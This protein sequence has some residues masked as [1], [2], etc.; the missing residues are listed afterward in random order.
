MSKLVDKI[1]PA[2]FKV[3]TPE[4]DNVLVLDFN[5]IIEQFELAKGRQDYKLIHWQGRPKGDRQWGIYD[6]QTDSYRC[7]VFTGHPAMYGASKLLMLDDATV[8]T[9]PSA[10]VWFVGSLPIV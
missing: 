5:P 2:K 8:T 9:I 6:P 1:G 3:T 10:V 7:G 4:V